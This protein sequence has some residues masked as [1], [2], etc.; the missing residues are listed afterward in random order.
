MNITDIPEINATHGSSCSSVCLVII[1]RWILFDS[2]CRRQHDLMSCC[3]WPHLHVCYPCVRR[4][5]SIDE[6][7]TTSDFSPTDRHERKQASQQH[8][9]YTMYYFFS[10]LILFLVSILGISMTHCTFTIN[11]PILFCNA[12]LFLNRWFGVDRVIFAQRQY[13]IQWAFREERLLLVEN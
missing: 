12:R 11:S 9:R 10:S 3:C 13:L 5:I 4:T 6:T 8:N 1:L 7:G 2:Q